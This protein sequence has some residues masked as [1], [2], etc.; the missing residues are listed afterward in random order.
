MCDLKRKRKEKKKDTASKQ[1]N[2]FFKKK[3]KRYNPDLQR[4][5][6][7]ERPSRLQAHAEFVNKLSEY[8]KSDKPIWV[9]AAEDQKRQKQEM[10][11]QRKRAQEGLERQRTEILEEQGR[12]DV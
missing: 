2:K 12:H 9:V 4:R 1:I 6:A 11:A 5:S 7:L 10:D 3:K 8:S